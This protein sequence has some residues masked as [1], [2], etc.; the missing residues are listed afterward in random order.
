MTYRFADAKQKLARFAGAYGLSDI[1]HAINEAMD[2]LAATKSWQ[3]MRKVQRLVVSSEF[4]AM[5]QDCGR[6]TRCAIDGVPSKVVGQDYEFLSAGIGDVDYFDNLDRGVINVKR[7][8]VFPT[9]NHMPTEGRLCAF[10]ATPPANGGVKARIRTPD[11]DIVDVTVP[12]RSGESTAYS[13]ADVSAGAVTAE[14]AVEVL[15]VTLPSDASAYIS[16]YYTDGSSFSFLSRMHPRIRVPEFTRYRLPGFEAGQTYR[17]LVECGLRFLP[18]VDDDEVIPL[19]S[20][21]PLQYTLQAFHAMD[22]GEVQSAENYRK[23]AELSMLRRE[24]TEN[25]KQGLLIIN[26]QLDG[27]GGEGSA[28]WENV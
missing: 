19:D 12:C 7:E 8:G 2:E 5:P 6:L 4:F 20:L 24:D 26:Q 14:T 13:A 11:G 25:E 21:R 18:L 15:S 22:S 3:R 10:S 16:L 17:L 9:M 1:S 27:S 28:Y 23:S